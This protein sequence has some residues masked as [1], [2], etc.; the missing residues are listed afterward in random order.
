M[1]EKPK[2][3]VVRASSTPAASKAA[4]ATSKKGKS[5]PEVTWKATP[6]AKAEASKLRLFSWI[7]WVLAIAGEIFAIFWVL[8]QSDIKMWLLI[9]MIVVIGGLALTGAV[10]WKKS[11]RLDPASKRDKVQF[12]VQNQLGAIITVIAFLPLIVMIFLNKDMD[13]KQKGIA[14]G[15]GI[16]VLLVVGWFAADFDPPSQEEYSNEQRIVM[17][18]TG[19]DKVYWTKSGKV[20][21]LCEDVSAVQQV[22]QDNQ[23]YEGTVGQAHAA[24]KDRLTKQ[25]EQEINQCGL[26]INDYNPNPPSG[27]DST[28]SPSTDDGTGGSEEPATDADST[29]PATDGDVTP[30]ETET[31]Q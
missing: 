9:L 13:G 23:I 1:A 3:K 7:L 16:V 24:G 18:L 19:E 6:E 4:E 14:G 22:S 27:T 28:P 25:V 21:H 11:N 31:T 20:F 17:E 26:D 30:E 10:L 2:K 5:L 15:L 12:F 8:Q 29:D